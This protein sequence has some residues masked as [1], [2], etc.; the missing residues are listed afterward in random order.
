MFSKTQSENFIQETFSYLDFPNVFY[1][2]LF[3]DKGPSY[4][5]LCL[6]AWLITLAFHMISIIIWLSI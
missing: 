6:F 1:L 2:H 4:L 3:Q 5:V